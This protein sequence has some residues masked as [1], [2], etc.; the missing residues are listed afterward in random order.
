MKR[1][2]RSEYIPD[3]T[4]RYSF[5][6]DDYWYDTYSDPFT[7]QVRWYN[8]EDKWTEILM[9]TNNRIELYQKRN[10]FPEDATLYVFDDTTNDYREVPGDIKEVIRNIYL[11]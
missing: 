7:Y 11:S 3:I 9:D 8:P 4:Q 10:D 2:I 6:F 5:G 1:Y